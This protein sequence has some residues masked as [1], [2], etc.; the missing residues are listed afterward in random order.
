PLL[1]A[2]GLGEL[3]EGETSAADPEH[4]GAALGA[5]A[6]DR[7]ARRRDPVV[8][9]LEIHSN[10]VA[11]AVAA[12]LRAHQEEWPAP[13]A[14]LQWSDAARFTQRVVRTLCPV[15]RDDS[16]SLFQLVHPLS[17]EDAYRRHVAGVKAART[18]W[19]P[20]FGEAV[21]AQVKAAMFSSIA[22]LGGR[23]AAAAQGGDG[24]PVLS[25]Q[26]VTSHPLDSYVRG[27][28][29]E[30]GVLDYS[31]G[32]RPLP[33]AQPAA[34]G[35]GAAAPPRRG[36][37]SQR[38]EA[39]GITSGPSSDGAAGQ[40]GGG[41]AR[42]VLTVQWLGRQDATLWNYVR[43][44]PPGASAEDVAAALYGSPEQ[45][46]MAFALQRHGD[47]FQVAPKQA[48]ELIAARYPGEVTG[49][50]TARDG[51]ALARSPL[52]DELALREARAALAGSAHTRR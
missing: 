3:G 43:V 9:Y 4:E 24:T 11:H 40:A 16:F 19:I 42:A 8:Q 46:R 30:E 33:A 52:G 35:R 31:G 17:P 5:A 7:E 38:D 18:T 28:L 39:R 25:S 26:V 47:L 50:G 32:W 13:S 41:R 22:R 37:A 36:Q 14:E 23:F 12:M 45:S 27:A 6:A 21:A 44:S 49:H 20:G 15:V 1:T 48:R 29:A 10:S 34:R 51:A 2:L